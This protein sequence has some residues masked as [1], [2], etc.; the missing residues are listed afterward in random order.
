[1]P[2]ADPGVDADEAEDE[3]PTEVLA[4]VVGKYHSQT[5]SCSARR[6]V[7]VTVESDVPQTRTRPSWW[8]AKHVKMGAGPSPRELEFAACEETV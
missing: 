1:M 5:T 6:S 3:E 7:K 8:L 4:E 2:E